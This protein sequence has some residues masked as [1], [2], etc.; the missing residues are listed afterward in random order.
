[1]PYAVQK[2]TGKLLNDQKHL[3]MHSGWFVKL[4]LCGYLRGEH[5]MTR[6]NAVLN[7]A[8]DSYP[9]DS[10]IFETGSVPLVSLW[11]ASIILH[12]VRYSIGDT[13]DMLLNLRANFDRDIPAF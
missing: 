13:P 2:A 7:A 11:Q 4:L 3:A 9:S 6:L 5:P 1:M 8:S 10:A 12:R